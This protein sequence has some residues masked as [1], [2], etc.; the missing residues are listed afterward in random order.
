[1]N[2]H[3]SMSDSYA[4]AFIGSWMSENWRF[5]LEIAKECSQYFGL[6]AE[7]LENGERDSANPRMELRD[8][9]LL[10]IRLFEDMRAKDGE[11]RGGRLYNP[12]NGKDYALRLSL[13]PEGKLIMR[14]FIGLPWIGMSQIWERFGPRQDLEASWIEAEAGLKEGQGWSKER[15]WAYVKAQALPLGCNYLP[16]QAVNQVQMWQK[17]GFDPKAIEAEL[18]LAASLGF[19]CLRVYL[20]DIPWRYDQT[21]FTQRLQR[22]LDICASLGLRII[23]VLFDDCWNDNPRPG[24]QKAPI[25][26][27]HNSRWLRSPGSRVINNPKSWA[28]QEDYL[29]SIVSIFKEDE[30]IYAWDLYNEIGNSVGFLPNSTRFLGS[31]FSWA[32]R[33]SPQAPLT[34]SI[35]KSSVWFGG[36]NEFLARNSDIISFHDYSPLAG[37]EGRIKSLSRYGKPLVCTEYMARSQG[38]R[39]ESHLPRLMELGVGALNWGLV[40]GRSQTFMPWGSRPGSS[41]PELWFHD[42]FR[43]D[44]SPYDPQELEVI[45]SQSRRC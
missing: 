15:A 41:E 22:F 35:W 7:G 37:L 40:A 3:S 6:L 43:P 42:I 33:I 16:S 34:S 11:L 23:P 12:E 28:A 17:G 18:G 19:N 32:R 27:V 20:H 2:Y 36:V 14:A 26:G 38:S 4:D 39:F 44:G 30:R 45:R 10:G 8:R 25:L 24:R 9:Q 21:G 1:M 13:S 29:S 31:C 5:R